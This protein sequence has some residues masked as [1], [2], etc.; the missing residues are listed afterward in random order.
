MD[1]DWPK[2]PS[3]RQLQEACKKT[4]RATTPAAEA[5][6]GASLLVLPGSMQ[7]KQLHRLHS[8]TSLGQSCPRK[9]K[10]SIHAHRVTSVMSN[11]L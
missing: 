10:T 4:D 9:K 5:V 8:Q 1:K 3:D 2:R 7:A 6:R 11:S